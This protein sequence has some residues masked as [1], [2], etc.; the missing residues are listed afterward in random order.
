M[1]PDLPSCTKVSLTDQSS[2]FLS[3]SFHRRLSILHLSEEHIDGPM[4]GVGARIGG[5]SG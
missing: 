5:M 4:I 1:L 2:R 3:C